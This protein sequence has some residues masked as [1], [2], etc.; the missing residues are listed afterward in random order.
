MQPLG[1]IA[2][3]ILVLPGVAMLMALRIFY[4]RQMVTSANQARLALSLVAWL[5]IIL[6][7]L[8]AGVGTLVLFSLVYLPIAIAVLFMLVDR[9]RRSEHHALLN[10]LAFSAEK[11]VPLPEAARAYSQEHAGDT[12]LRALHLA[13]QI[14]AGATLGA[15]TRHARLRLATP[16]RL[17]VNLS[18]VLTLR[19]ITLRSQV[20]WGNDTDA[21]FRIII[22][23]LLYLLFISQA[24][25]LILTFVM[26]KIVPVFQR[27]FEE[28]GLRLPLPTEMLIGASKWMVHIGWMYLAPLVPLSVAALLMGFLYYSGWY[29]FPVIPGSQ[30]SERNRY[31]PD[32]FRV[33]DLFLGLRFLLWRYDASLVLRS[34]ALLI[35]QRMP[36]P[37]AM[38]LLANVYPRGNV[39]RRLTKVAMEINRG[40]DWKLALRNQWL[41]GPSEAAVLGAAERAGNL[42]WALDEMGDS[43]MRRLTYRLMVLHQV[44][45]P[46]LLLALGGVVACVVIGLMLPLIALI[47]GLT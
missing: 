37:E 21:T 11:G 26:I 25:G 6:A 8:G 15:A 3:L 36:L 41:L 2:L 47:Q 31:R 13:K 16:M 29:D 27:M 4:R 34:L 1:P 23:R 30:R 9:L 12:G 44:L 32:V 5:L 14:E 38:V 40:G 10:C 33:M 19:G 39:R 17:A 43:L 24:L 20:N 42:G 28:F 35:Q 18:D 46:V 22:N 7:I 45:Y